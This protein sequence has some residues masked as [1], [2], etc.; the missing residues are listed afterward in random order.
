MNPEVH[1]L[2]HLPLH[3][4]IFVHLFDFFKDNL[5]TTRTGL[6]YPLVC[7]FLIR[8]VHVTKCCPG[9]ISN[10]VTDLPQEEY[11]S[12]CKI[13]KFA[14]D[15]IVDSHT[16]VTPIILR[17]AGV[18]PTPDNT[19]GFLQM[20][21]NVTKYGPEK[22][23]SFPYLSLQEFLAAFYITQL[24]KH[25]Q[26][27]PFKQIFEQ[28]PLSSVLTFYAG[29]TSLTGVPDE[30]CHLLFRVMENG[31]DFKT[32]VFNTDFNMRKQ[33]LAFLNC[34][35]ESQKIELLKCIPF[36]PQIPQ[37]SM[38]PFSFS[39]RDIQTPCIEIP[40]PFCV[41]L[42]PTDCLSIGYFARH[43]CEIVPTP[44]R[45]ILNLFGCML[46]EQEIR[47]LLQELCKLIRSKNHLCLHLEFNILKEEA[48]QSIQRLLTSQSGLIGLSITADMIKDIKLAF[49]YFIEGNPLT[50][51]S[52]PGYTFDC[53]I[54]HHIVL[55][56]YTNKRL[57]TLSLYG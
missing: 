45:I 34:I 6:F 38:P 50:H 15:S 56:L 35:Y 57:T 26:V 9:T 47:A 23:Y 11:L 32:V 29:L 5:P 48:L 43:V 14:Y 44:S 49:K 18:D 54:I 4:V 12:L 2:C 39:S 36:S 24:E 16:L 51:L 31:L 41:F 19:F 25:D 28:N 37:D 17:S 42:Y 40:L 8:H 21:Y 30:I 55:L 52:I 3:A 27:I 22:H 13:S 46:K 20:H 33:I 10:L 53:H 7:N 1:S